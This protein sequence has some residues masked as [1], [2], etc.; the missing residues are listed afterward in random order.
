MELL[1]TRFFP[2]KEHKFQLLDIIRTQ[3][4][5][6]AATAGGRGLSYMYEMHGDVLIYIDQFLSR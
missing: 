6:T 1:W 3:G 2:E 5:F 4:G